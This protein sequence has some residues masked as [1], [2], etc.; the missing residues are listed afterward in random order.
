MVASGAT[1]LS[2]RHINQ[3]IR[4]QVL[5]LLINSMKSVTGDLSIQN[6]AIMTTIDIFGNPPCR[7][8][9]D[10]LSI[11]VGISRLRLNLGWEGY[12]VYC[13]LIDLLATF[14]SVSFP[15]DYDAVAFRLGANREI[16]RS[17]IEDYGLFSME[18]TSDET[19][20]FFSPALRTLNN[21][22]LTLHEELSSATT[23]RRRTKGAPAEQTASATPTRTAPRQTTVTADRLSPQTKTKEEP[24]HMAFDLEKNVKRLVSDENWLAKMSKAANLDMDV[25]AMVFERFADGVLA[26]G[27]GGYHSFEAMTNHLINWLRKGCGDRIIKQAMDEVRMRRE[28][29]RREAERLAMQREREEHARKAITYTE[30]LRRRSLSAQQER[31]E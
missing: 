28:Q 23:K 15:A 16:V 6:K 5:T 7:N 12:G 10:V 30:Y 25:F 2:S 22:F 19:E 31:V 17:V 26:R 9:N 18:T 24:A 13:A 21:R 11:P 27:R 1:A 29:E 20:H 14:E 3:R 4:P 8:L